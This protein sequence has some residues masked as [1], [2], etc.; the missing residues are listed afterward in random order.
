M[1]ELTHEDYT[2]ENIDGSKWEQVNN[3]LCKEGDYIE[4]DSPNVI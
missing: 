1:K 4:F 3:H 2:C